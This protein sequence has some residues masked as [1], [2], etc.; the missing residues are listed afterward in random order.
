MRF[1]HTS[2]W[3]IG[4][5]FHNVS[6]LDD[7]AHVLEQ[8]IQIA[9]RKAVDAIF[10]AGDIYDRAIPPAAAV[11]LLDSV[12]DRIVNELQIPLIVISGNHD[13]AARLSFAAKQLSRSGLHIIADL[14]EIPVPL[15]L[16][17]TDGEVAIWGIPYADPAQVRNALDVEVSDHNSAMAAVVDRIKAQRGQY[18]RNVAI[19]HC[20]IDGALECDSERPLSIGGADRIDWQLFADFDYVALGH[21][22]G[23][24]FRGADHIRYSGSILKYSFS[25][26]RQTKSVTI[27][28]MD[29]QGHCKTDYVPLVA[30]RDMRTL[31]GS[32]DEILAAGAA[33]PKRDDYLLVKLNDDIAILDVMGKLR[34]VYPNVLHLERPGLMKGTQDVMRRAK[35]SMSELQMF[36]SFFQQV[37]GRKFSDQEASLARDVIEQLHDDRE[38]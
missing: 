11:S 8:V 30:L 4:R 36:D 1:L 23:R 3:H 25:E 9:K 37:V 13:S 34:E 20:F 15:V 26:E 29:A 33:D 10:V 35:Q 5:Q 19:S 21:L 18:Q 12:V 32:L 27:V 31:T 2:D 22:H 14:C 28:D 24:Q 6:L 17:D 7:Q 38:L 16:D